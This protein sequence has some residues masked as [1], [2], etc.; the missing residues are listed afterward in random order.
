MEGLFVW[1]RRIVW[2][3]MIVAAIWVF[4][5]LST[6]YMTCRADGNGKLVCA[7]IAVMV[8]T[9]EVYGFIAV[10]VVRVLYAVL[11]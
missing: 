8:T 7:G 4:S 9:I 6:N 2:L 10:T 11:P 5:H 1:A 3:A